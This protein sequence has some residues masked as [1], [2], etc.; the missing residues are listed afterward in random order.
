VIISSDHAILK[1]RECMK[2]KKEI[3]LG[4]GSLLFLVL[5]VCTCNLIFV[6]NVANA[7]ATNVS[8]LKISGT[9]ISNW[10][11]SSSADSFTVWTAANFYDDVDGGI[12]KY[13]N[14]GMIEVAD[15]HMVGPVGSDGQLNSIATHSFIM[16]YGNDSNAIAIYN[17][18]RTL[19]SA[20]A[21]KIPRYPLTSAFAINVI[22]GITV[23]AHFKKFYF[24][25]T[26]F[27]FSDNNQAASTAVQFLGLFRSKIQ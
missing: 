25:L 13:L 19:Y 2:K 1:K 15:I 10:K 18:Q 4:A 7:K 12:D 16:D 20:E 24:E 6:E 14:N 3:L 26:F 5:I 8:Q 27:G 17:Y 21:F 11:L 9:E 22:G 23:M